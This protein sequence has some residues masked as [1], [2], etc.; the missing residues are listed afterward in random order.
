MSASVEEP[1]TEPQAKKGS[2]FS[3]WPSDDSMRHITKSLE[4]IIIAAFTTKNTIPFGAL[5]AVC[6][7][8][9]RLPEDGLKEIILRMVD[10]RWFAV[11]G[12]VLLLVALVIGYKLFT[13]REK[14]HV[15][16]LQ[17]II[18]VRDRLVEEQLKLKLDSTPLKLE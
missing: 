7:V 8:A 13:W 17:Q 6:I 2:S 5:V 12:W 3:P 14:L 18:K 9:Y 16:E 11:L 4:R 1:K 10:A 15:A